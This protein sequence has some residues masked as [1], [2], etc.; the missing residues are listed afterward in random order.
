MGKNPSS[1]ITARVTASTL[2]LIASVVLIVLALNMNVLAIPPAPQNPSVHLGF[3]NFPGP[4]TLVQVASS[5]QGPTAHTVE[6]TAH[7]AGEPSCG[8]N[9]NSPAPNN[10]AGVT[11]FQ[12]DL[13]TLFIT[14]DDSCPASGQKATWYNSAAPTSLFID[15]DPIGFTDRQTGRVFAGEL[16][17]TSPSCKISFTDT[18]GLDALGQPDQAGWTASIPPLGS[19]IDHETIGGGPY[20]SPIPARPPGTVYPNAVYYCSQDLVAAFCLRS[21]D[22]GVNWGPP[23]T[24]YTSAC[25]GLHGHV[26]VAPDG[27]V[28]VPNNDCGSKGAVVASTDNGLTWT[29]RPVT[30][31]SSG[32]SDP[33]VGIDNNGKVYFAIANGDGK[34]VV[35]TSNDLGQ[36]WQNIFD[37]GAAFGV[38][39]TAYPAAVAADTNRAAVSF[40]GSTTAGDGSSSGF[41][42]VWHLYIAETIDGGAHWNTADAT[43]NAP[44]QRGCIWNGGGANICR[45]LLDFF[46]MTVDKQGR[47]EVGYVN[48]CAGG[49]CAQAAN[50][51]TGNAYTALG[52]I[53]RQSSGQ[54]LI[55]SFD[56]SSPTSVPGIPSVTERRVGRAI[57]IAWSEADTGNSPI[58][59]YQILRG[60]S[61][62]TE[63]LLTTVAGTQTG[64]TFDDFDVTVSGQTTYYYKV[65]ATNG[66]GTSCGNNE[67]AA[68][69]NGDGCTGL[70]VQ[71]TPPGHPEQTAQGQAPMSLAIDSIA[72][73][74]PP[75]TSNLM[76][77]MKVTS[78]ATVPPNSRWR[79]IWD[80]FASPG[81]QFYIGMRTDSNSVATFDYGTIATAVVGL[82]IGVPTETLIG[83][84]AAGSNFNPDGTITVYVPKTVVGNPQP[85]DLLGAVG[86]RTF[87]GDTPDTNTLERST[88][89]IDHTFVKGQRD[90]GEPP[91]TYTVAG[92]ISCALT[93]VVSRMTHGTITPPFDI[94]LPL[95]PPRGVECRSSALLGAGNYMLVFTFANNLS[96]VANATVTSHDPATG[97]GSVSGS[98]LGPNPNQYT[99]N[100]TNVSTGQY[101]TVTLNSVLDVLGNGGNVLSPQMGVL[102]GDVNFNGVASNADVSLVKAQVAA[103]ASVGPSNFQDDI[104]ANGVISNADVSLTKAQVA[105]GAQLPSPP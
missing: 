45:N 26:K 79:I 19:G 5:S 53:A 70:I 38:K 68:P 73:G 91:A 61:S 32:F 44:M 2:F 12:S 8:V 47:I 101:I 1:S 9:W 50:T 86:G 63:T 64:G 33:A 100:L 105:A 24:I 25:G 65:Q 22:G 14:F 58:T 54:R 30:S 11:N 95:T 42:G 59:G 23:V 34:A 51:A 89:L 102:V 36:T 49:N 94:N 56:P 75:G 71:R 43:P 20:H 88:A 82:V 18:N 48:G 96:S 35:A 39:T 13:Q 66:V 52:V 29:P 10:A 21:D 16:T 57:H 28:Y 7:D 41:N 69:F 80:S 3:E 93:S 76:F 103:G 31:T 74:E 99:V 40:Y 85:G 27:T 62:N 60:T 37:V 104:N 77:K 81:Q 98:G 87:T 4:G 97:T 55:A 90:N 92:S 17:L 15:S 6:Y 84:A 67:I 78:L 83:N 72:V 46:D